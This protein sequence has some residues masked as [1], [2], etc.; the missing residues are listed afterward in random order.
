VT[1]TLSLSS[2]AREI[3]SGSGLLGR[4]PIAQPGERFDYMVTLVDPERSVSKT[5]IE[6]G[7][8]G[9]EF[10]ICDRYSANGTLLRFSEGPARL[11]EPG[12]R[13]RVAR[14][15]RVEIGDQFFDV[16]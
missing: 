2:G 7:I 16:N 4:R 5:H 1:Y 14:G 9:G 11:C 13:Y 15:S 3:V 10:W 6:F 8:E 12:R